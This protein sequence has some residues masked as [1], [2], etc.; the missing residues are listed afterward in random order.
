[1]LSVG[2]AMD[3]HHQNR[4]HRPMR[5]LMMTMEAIVVQRVETLVLPLVPFETLAPRGPVDHDIPVHCR[6][7]G[8]IHTHTVRRGWVKKTHNRERKEEEEGEVLHQSTTNPK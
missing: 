3:H 7:S 5:R 4:Y 8:T 1:M 2:I 6:S